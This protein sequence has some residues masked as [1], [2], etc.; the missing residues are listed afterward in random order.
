MT[1]VSSQ[2][3]PLNLS[4]LVTGQDSDHN[5]T[6]KPLPFKPDYCSCA[7]PDS[8]CKMGMILVLT[9]L[10]HLKHLAQG[11]EQRKHKISAKDWLCG[12]FNIS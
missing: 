12:K 3:C 5:I 7:G 9:W 8:L 4:S 10:V 11:Q 6:T 2:F 1:D